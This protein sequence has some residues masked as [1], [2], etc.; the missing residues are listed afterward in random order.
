M[1]AERD[2]LRI[3]L[4]VPLVEGVDTG[5]GPRESIEKIASQICFELGGNPLPIESAV[6]R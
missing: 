2:A 1:L 4:G 6:A 3:N 5:T